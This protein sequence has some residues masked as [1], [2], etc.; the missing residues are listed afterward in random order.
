MIGLHDV[1]QTPFH[2]VLRE[3][4]GA[5]LRSRRVFGE[6]RTPLRKTEQGVCIIFGPPLNHSRHTNGSRCLCDAGTLA[7]II[8]A[9]F[10]KAQAMTE[11]L[12][13]GRD[14]SPISH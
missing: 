7:E 8:G 9:F 12:A 10:T 14:N 1:M 2:A 13:A 3:S 4:V 5:I 6:L 11:V